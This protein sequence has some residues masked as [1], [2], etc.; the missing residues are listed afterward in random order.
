MS[1]LPAAGI[2]VVVGMWVVVAGRRVVAVGT[3]SA[4]GWLAVLAPGK[5]AGVS[6]LP[7][8]VGAGI[9]L[10]VVVDAVVM[11]ARLV[12]LRVFGPC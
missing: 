1:G 6:G 12:A 10:A 9:A 3:A 8:A 5:R 11:V 2:R 4:V 7:A